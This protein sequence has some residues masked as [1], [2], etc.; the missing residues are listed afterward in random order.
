MKRKHPKSSVIWLSQKYLIVE[1]MIEQYSL[2]TDPK[3]MK[4]IINIKSINQIQQ[5][6]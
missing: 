1:N 5:N 6:R 3:I 2:K 4:Y